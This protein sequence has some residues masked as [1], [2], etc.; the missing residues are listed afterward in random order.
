MSLYST[1]ISL[2]DRFISIRFILYESCYMG[3]IVWTMWYEPYYMDHTTKYLWC[4]QN[5]WPGQ[6]A[7]LT[8]NNPGHDRSV[9]GRRKILFH[10]AFDDH[11]MNLKIRKPLKQFDSYGM[12]HTACKLYAY[13]DQKSSDL[14]TILIL[15]KN[16]FGLTLFD[17]QDIFDLFTDF[18]LRY[19]IYLVHQSYSKVHRLWTICPIFDRFD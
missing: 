18:Y 13:S 12:F 11:L 3:H 16:A 15:Q 9:Y 7:S 19:L 2:N 5:F 17:I 4:G 6:K 8:M 14:F 10:H 1:P